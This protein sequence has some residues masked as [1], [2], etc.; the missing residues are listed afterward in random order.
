MTVAMPSATRRMRR[1]WIAPLILVLAACSTGPVADDAQ[2]E[3]AP[4]TAPTAPEVPP[5]WQLLRDEPSGIALALPA[6]MRRIDGF[7]AV[8]AQSTVEPG[9]F[10]LEVHSALQRFPPPPRPWNE[11][12]LTEWLTQ[13]AMYWIPGELVAVDAKAVEL[14][15]GDAIELRAQIETRGEEDAIDVRAYAIPTTSGVL[16]LYILAPLSTATQRADELDLIPRLL[17]IDERG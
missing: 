15:A 11:P 17:T 14:P 10:T 5:G 7:P 3:S 13:G 12:T 1:R 9:T 2:P 8:S 6:D 16:D 4:E